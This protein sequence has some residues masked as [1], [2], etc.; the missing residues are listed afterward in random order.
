MI[1][2]GEAGVAE[3]LAWCFHSPRR[4]AALAVGLLVLLI[5]AG[6]AVGAVRGGGAPAAVSATTAGGVPGTGPAVQAALAFT[7][8]WAS[9][10]ASDTA[11]EWRAALR[12]LATPELARGL[13]ITDPSTLPGG[14]PSGRATVR[15]VATSSAL[16]EVPLSSGSSVLVTVVV[17]GGRWLASDVQPATGDP[18]DVTAAGAAA[19]VG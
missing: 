17:V 15:F 14:G 7:R 10:P 11:D 4:L 18:G 6:A 13:A 12:P 9:K 1:L 8:V 19:P 2:P 3:L 16:I 5:G